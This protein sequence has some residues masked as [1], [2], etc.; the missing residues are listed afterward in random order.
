[1]ASNRELRQ[2]IKSIQN[3][4]QVT[5]A[6]ET[7]SASKVKSATKAA[8]NSRPYSEKAWKVLKHLAQQ[9]GHESVHPLLTDRESINNIL[10]ILITSDRGLNGAYNTNITKYTFDYFSNDKSSY[11]FVTVGKKGRDLLRRREMKIIADFSDLPDHLQ[12]SDLS[13]LGSKV[14]DEFMNKN[15]DEVYIAYTDFVSMAVQKPTITRLLPI[16]IDMSNSDETKQHEVNSNASYIYEPEQTE[17]LNQ[18]IPRFTS[19]QIYQSIL[20]AQASDHAARMIAMRN[21]TENAVELSSKLQLVYNK[22]RQQTITNDILD[23][24]GGSSAIG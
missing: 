2:R 17:L 10:I 24:V 8:L 7:V 9:P 22:A 11:S 14:I 15:N 4:S 5:K 12:Y 19:V 13:L 20:S 1:M 23:I 18:I 3:I 6:L 21:A 16:T